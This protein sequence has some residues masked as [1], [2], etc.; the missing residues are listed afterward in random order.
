MPEVMHS[1]SAGQCREGGLRF[2]R[3][4][5]VT[6]VFPNAEVQ[7]NGPR[8]LMGATPRRWHPESRPASASSGALPLAVR[9]RTAALLH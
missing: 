1:F 6:R 4:D 9:G 3:S 8:G 5:G 2:L 7:A